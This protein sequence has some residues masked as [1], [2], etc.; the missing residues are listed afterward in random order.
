MTSQPQTAFSRDDFA[1]AL[2]RYDY[3]SNKGQVVRGRIVEYLTDGALVDMGGKSS[4][5][6]SRRD[7]ALDEVE[8]LAEV[9]PLETEFEFLVTSEQNADGQVRLSRRQLLIQEVWDSLGELQEQQQVIEIK[10]NG[11]NR[12]GITGMYRGLRGFVPRSQL[13]GRHENLDALIGETISV[14]II[15]ADSDRNKLVLSQ[16]EA[17]RAAMVGQ[18]VPGA[19]MTGTVV[20]LK[21]YGAFVD[22]NGVTGLLHVKQI[23][24]KR[25]DSIEA[26]LPVGTELKVVIAELDEWKNRISLAT[27]MLEAYPGEILENFSAVMANAEERLAQYGAAAEENEQNRSIGT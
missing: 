3:Q 23:S 11:S 16:R 15:E 7:A 22:L 8:D 17:A 18:L 25:T 12:G 9:L 14:V 4:G 24:S 13:V 10:I 21:P 20:S 27:R 1:Q 6:V 5:F 2:E 19:L 26:L